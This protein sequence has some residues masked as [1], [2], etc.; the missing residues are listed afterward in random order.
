[1]CC[2]VVLSFSNLAKPHTCD[3]RLSVPDLYSEVC[4]YSVPHYS[5]AQ[6]ETAESTSVGSRYLPKTTAITFLLYSLP[7]TFETQNDELT[8]SR[9]NPVNS[10]PV[11]QS[12][13]WLS[14]VWSAP[15]EL[16][17]PPPGR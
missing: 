9:A 12:R 17:R 6:R 14:S 2:I 8:S 3:A 15:S 7:H 4:G 10:D 1:M 11:A 16:W 13:P 5:V